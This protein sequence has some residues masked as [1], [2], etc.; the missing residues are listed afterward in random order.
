[1]NHPFLEIV[2]TDTGEKV[3]QIKIDSNRLEAMVVEKSGSRLFLN[4]TEKNSIGGIDLE[5]QAVAAVWPLACKVNLSVAM[6]AQNSRIYV[7]CADE[8]ITMRDSASCKW[9]TS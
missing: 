9:R 6:D 5:K 4:M 8:N 2:N 3:G 7:A 1:M